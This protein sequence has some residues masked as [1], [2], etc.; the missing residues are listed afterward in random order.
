MEE[1][2]ELADH[3]PSFKEEV[4]REEKDAEEKKEIL[5]RDLENFDHKEKILQEE[6]RNLVSQVDSLLLE[7]YE[8]LRK[9]KD[10][11]AVVPVKDG[12]CD[13]CNVKVSPSLIGRVKRGEIT[14]C[15][16]CNRIL[17]IF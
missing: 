2:E 11:V 1:E 7:Q 6:R 8:Q 12:I 14:Y 15:E 17:Y 16:S 4:E 10:K 13:G 9:T 3:L 5:S